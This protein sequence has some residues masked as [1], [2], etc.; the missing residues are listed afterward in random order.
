MRGNLIGQIF[1]N[2]L[3]IKGLYRPLTTT[4]GYVRLIHHRTLVMVAKIPRPLSL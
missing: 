2:D 4:Q 3:K 1:L